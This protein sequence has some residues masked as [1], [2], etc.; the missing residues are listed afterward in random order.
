MNKKNILILSGVDSSDNYEA[1]K[2]IKEKYPKFKKLCYVPAQEE[3]SKDEFKQIKKDFKTK[4]KFTNLVCT[5][6]ESLSAGDVK[7]R[8]LDADVL[9]LGGGNTFD[10][11][12]NLQAKKLSSTLK[13][14]LAEG[15]LIIGLSAGGILLT[16]SLMMACY[17]SKDADEYNSNLKNLKGY[18]YLPFE[19]CPHYKNSKQMNKDLITYSALHDLPVYGVRDGGFIALDEAGSFYSLGTPMFYRGEKL[20]LN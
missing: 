8:I 5:P 20:R 18:G 17:P 3:G 11:Y 14:F 1:L 9:F 4:L 12:E 19:V 6:L 16:P 13:K 15:K 10:F 7:K 2:Y